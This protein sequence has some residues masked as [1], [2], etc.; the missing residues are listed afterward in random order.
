MAHH[1][2]IRAVRDEAARAQGRYGDFHS[3][4][5]ALGVLCEEFDE[6]RAAIHGNSPVTIATEAT[7]VAAVAMRL[8]D[9]CYRAVTARDQDIGADAFA[10]RSGF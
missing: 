1:D 10:A 9:L 3:T 5:E 4:H 7:Q 8:A 6:L 2:A